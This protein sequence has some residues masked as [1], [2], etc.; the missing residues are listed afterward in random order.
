[1]ASP[2]INPQHFSFST[3]Q[4]PPPA[5]SYP[6]SYYGY[7]QLSVAPQPLTA[8]PPPPLPRRAPPPP[9]PTSYHP[10]CYSSYPAPP[11]Y[12]RLPPPPPPP[13]SLMSAYPFSCL[14]S[15]PRKAPPPPPPHRPSSPYAPPPPPPS[16]PPPPPFGYPMQCPPPPPYPPRPP[17]PPPLRP[18]QAPCPADPSVTIST[19]PSA[20]EDKLPPVSSAAIIPLSTSETPAA[21][22]GTHELPSPC[23]VLRPT[24]AEETATLSS[25]T[26]QARPTAPWPPRPEEGAV[27]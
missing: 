11:R 5:Y 1:M 13:S 24:E 15:Q 9:P 20:V 12:P 2:Y 6:S 22:K 18:P 4:R 25:I 10:A 14:Y 27:G 17:P 26:D 23:E 7:H 8:P 3:Q 21:D 19:V 16:Q